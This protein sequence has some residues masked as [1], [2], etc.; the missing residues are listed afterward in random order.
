MAHEHT[1]SFK[2]FLQNEGINE[3]RR[4]GID[5][6]VVSSFN[7]LREK[8]RAVFP[9]LHGCDFIVA[10]RDSDGDE[11]V[12]SSDEELIIALTELQTEVR[13]LY[14][15]V[16]SGSAEQHGEGQHQQ[17]VGVTCDA[18]QKEVEGFRY[19]CI[20]CPDFDLCATCESKGLHPEHCMI[21]LPVPVSWRHHFGRRL[22]HHLAKAA[23]KGGACSGLE[24]KTGHGQSRPFSGRHHGGRRNG[25]PSW[26]ETL[27]AYLSDWS[28][29]PGEEDPQAKRDTAEPSTSKQQESGEP[30]EEVHVQY[31]RNI[32]QTVATILDPLGIDVDIE[33]RSKNKDDKT[34]TA[35]KE[36]NQRDGKNSSEE[37]NNN[38]MEVDDKHDKEANAARSERE[39]PEAEGWTVVNEA[40]QHQ[41]NVTPNQ[42]AGAAKV[43]G[44]ETGAVPKQL[45][46]PSVPAPVHNNVPPSNNI[47]PNVFAL[48]NHVPLQPVQ[49]PLPPN[50]LPMHFPAT[51]APIQFPGQAFVHHHR[52]PHIAEALNKMMSMG[53]SN[54]GGWLTQLLE[55]KD[56]SIDKALD[57][58]QPVKKT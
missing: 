18:C 24:F 52:K 47:Y 13:K 57:V 34:S 19:K 42:S 30:M 51:S 39:S 37:E 48:P 2:V 8:L 14:V 23:H 44:P 22:A 25:G 53:F 49:A 1:V 40:T 4:F 26:L 27:A 9:S 28:N 32:G 17:H 46:T 12:I 15:T 11:I 58:L 50:P 45:D 16:Q 33:V 5:R 3:V 10:W 20:Q 35:Q 43:P 21:R 56:G 7:Y 41:G 6:D 36:C 29:L 31:L 38:A 54:D 55:S